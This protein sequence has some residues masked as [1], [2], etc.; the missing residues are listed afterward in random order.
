MLCNG[1]YLCL[2]NTKEISILLAYTFHPD[3]I[4]PE[5]ISCDTDNLRADVCVDTPR[6]AFSGVPFIQLLKPC[7]YPARLHDLCTP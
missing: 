6:N 5:Q 2:V 1:S 4:G 3:R 7:F